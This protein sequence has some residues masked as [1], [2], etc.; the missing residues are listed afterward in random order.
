MEPFLRSQGGAE[1]WGEWAEAG[2]HYHSA[3]RAIVATSMVSR[4]D[5]KKTSLA[6][7]S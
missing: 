1:A 7:T 6:G 2:E 5:Q 3:S 4:A